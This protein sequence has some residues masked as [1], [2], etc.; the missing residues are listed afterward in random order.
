VAPRLRPVGA[1]LILTPVTKSLARPKSPTPSYRR[2]ALLER[3]GSS[4]KITPLADFQHLHL[5]SKRM[6]L[7]LRD[8]DFR[9]AGRR[10]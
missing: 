3:D 2:R 8:R 7:A 9:F 10:V 6:C 5:P 1:L 4:I